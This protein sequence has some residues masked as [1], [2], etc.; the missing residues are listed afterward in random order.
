MEEILSQGRQQSNAPVIDY[1]PNYTTAE[2][3]D[4]HALVNCEGVARKQLQR[5]YFFAE[6]VAG[7]G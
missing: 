2:F 3:V 7:G 5:T 6:W 1:I 4:C